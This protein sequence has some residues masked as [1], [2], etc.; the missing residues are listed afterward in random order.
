MGVDEQGGH[1]A[2]IAGKCHVAVVGV[3]N[4]FFVG[5]VGVKSFHNQIPKAEIGTAISLPTGLGGSYARG[6][7][8]E[9][10]GKLDHAEACPRTAAATDLTDAR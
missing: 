10:F 6:R 1:F 8:I 7:N 2:A 5:W 3:R 9:A 4:W